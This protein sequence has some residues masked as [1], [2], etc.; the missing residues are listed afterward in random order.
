MSYGTSFVNQAPRNQSSASVPA[1]TLLALAV[2]T[3]AL[4]LAGLAYLSAAQRR[5]DLD[6]LYERFDEEIAQWRQLLAAV[7]Q[8]VEEAYDR[9]TQPS[10]PDDASVRLQG[11]TEG[12][13]ELRNDLRNVQVLLKSEAESRLATEISLFDALDDLRKRSASGGAP[14]APARRKRRSESVFE[15]VDLGKSE[16]GSR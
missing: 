8:R 9:A 4:L 1:P 7:T 11:A 16:G 5:R 14:A 6:A 13:E 15:I 2:S 12:V 3:L 10:M